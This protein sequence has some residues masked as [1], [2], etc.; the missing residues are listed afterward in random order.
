MQEGCQI[1][2]LSDDEIEQIHRGALSILW[3]TGVEV[4][5]EQAFDILQKAGCPTDGKRIR[6]P[7]SL[8]EEAVRLAPKAF[9]LYGRDPNFKV[10]LE[11]RK[12]FYEPMIG[13]LNI[14]DLETS[15]RRR[16]TLD[17]VEKLIRVA[18]ALEHYTLLHSGAIMPHIEGI[19]DEVAHVYGYFASVK[20]SSKVIKGVVRGKQR[21]K[22]CIR[23]ASVIAGGEEALR[24][25]PNIFTTC[26]VISPLEYMVEQTEGLIEYAKMGLPVDIASE[27]Q[28][29]A[30]SPVTLAGTI[31]QQ[32]AEIL[33]MIV[34]A[35]LINPGTPVLMGTVAAAMDLRNGMIA[36]GGVE[37]AL[38]NVAHAQMARFYQIPSRGTGSNTESKLLDMQAGYEKT[39]TLLLPALAGINMIFYPGTMDHALTVSL[40]SL[41]IDHEI[42][43]MIDRIIKGVSV[44][45][46]RIA[47]DIIDK[48]GP[49][50]HF[51]NQKHTM[52]HLREEHFLPKLTDRDS[53]ELW[54][55]K[56]R[57]AIQERAREEVKRV[58]AEHE[59]LPLDAD[60][61]KELLAI[62][63]EVEKREL[64]KS[65]EPE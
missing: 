51:L 48:V 5:E 4:W 52:K 24:R 62:I 63:K 17:D 10:T 42:C 56:G 39:I 59:P 3:R 16:T 46:E 9:T 36:L 13:R 55:E 7:S 58:L 11:G 37:A 25:Y 53:H 19:P 28:C 57:K 23:M 35:Q 41:L 14:L 21:A 61:E 18:D 15:V 32:T 30:T 22:D 44:T 8:V 1:R 47:L 29:G 43:G 38:I 31:V 26:N 34:I 45:E 12:I 54:I 49:G 2:L 65:S 60:V 33:G 40:E 64:G 27:P 20:N 6:I 50:G